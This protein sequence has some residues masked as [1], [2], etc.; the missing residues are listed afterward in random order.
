MLARHD[1]LN[2]KYLLLQLGGLLSRARGTLLQRPDCRPGLRLRLLGAGQISLQRHRALQLL[3]VKALL[4]RQP[5][6]WVGILASRPHAVSTRET[7]RCTVPMQ[8]AHLQL[9][10]ILLQGCHPAAAGC[11]VCCPQRHLAVQR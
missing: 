6:L 9:L 2:S 7:Q 11:C 1:P 10:H 4:L 3:P 8:Q 5:L